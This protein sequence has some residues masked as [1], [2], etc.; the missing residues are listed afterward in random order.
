MKRLIS[1][2]LGFLTVVTCAAQV[3]NPSII[4]VPTGGTATVA[5]ISPAFTSTSSFG[6]T[7]SDQ[8]TAAN[9]SNAIPAS[10]SSIAVAG[11]GTDVIFYRCIGNLR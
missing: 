7:S 1:T 6:C 11:T 4:L 10:T 3:S 8:T 9:G 2:I 5:S